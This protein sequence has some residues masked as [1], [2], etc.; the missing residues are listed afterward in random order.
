MADANL[1]ATNAP[2]SWM[3]T[4]TSRQI[5]FYEKMVG[6]KKELWPALRFARYLLNA[7]IVELF[8]L[9]PCAGSSDLR[10]RV[11]KLQFESQDLLKTG[12]G[13]KTEPLP[14]LESLHHKL[15]LIAGQLAKI[16]VK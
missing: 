8:E 4:E 1:I 6:E 13:P 12:D 14:Q 7:G 2:M 9:N 16:A 15:D 5:A 3:Y 10:K 11:E